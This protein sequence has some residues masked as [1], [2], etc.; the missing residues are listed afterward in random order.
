[1]VSDN[2]IRGIIAAQ[3][4][5]IQELAVAIENQGRAIAANVLE[6]TAQGIRIDAQLEA[7]MDRI[8]EIG[9]L[10]KVQVKESHEA[11]LVGIQ[12]GLNSVR[13]WMNSMQ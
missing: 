2:K 12:N 3:N 4:V 13:H 1:M 9:I 11:D 6:T 10:Q 8:N 5:V 7:G